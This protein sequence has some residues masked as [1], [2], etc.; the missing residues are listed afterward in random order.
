M[1]LTKSPLT[2]VVLLRGVPKVSAAA[3]TLQSRRA[4]SSNGAKSDDFCH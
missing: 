2:T 1:H 3:C 4:S